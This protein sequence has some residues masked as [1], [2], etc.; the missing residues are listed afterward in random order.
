MKILKP[1]IATS[2]V[3]LC[4]AANVLATE[5]TYSVTSKFGNHNP[6]IGKSYAT[7]EITGWAPCS[8][9]VGLSA[10]RTFRAQVKIRNDDSSWS[11]TVTAYSANSEAKAVSDATNQRSSYH[12]TNVNDGYGNMGHST[13]LTTNV[14][15]S[16]T[17]TN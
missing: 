17:V 14:T 4:F 16:S 1:L 15:I 13:T 7:S 6:L 10:T 5:A 12:Y 9:S 8:G 11:S 3:V 2:L